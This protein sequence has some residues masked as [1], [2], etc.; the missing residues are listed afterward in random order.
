MQKEEDKNQRIK[1]GI[2]IGDVNGIGPEVI[3]RALKDS[4]VL[5]E[6]T[7]IIYGSNNAIT[8]SKNKIGANDFSFKFKGK[9]YSSKEGRAIS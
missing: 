3:V 2:T 7:P 9:T 8:N 5:Q 6:F 1:V 4:R